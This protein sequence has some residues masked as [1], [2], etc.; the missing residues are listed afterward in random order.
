MRSNALQFVTN[1]LVTFGELSDGT[2]V[3]RRNGSNGA[4]LSAS[5]VKRLARGEVLVATIHS[6]LGAT[7]DRANGKGDHLKPS[8]KLRTFYAAIERD[9]RLDADGRRE[10]RD[11][12]SE[13][14]HDL[15]KG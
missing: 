4:K 3:S 7:I 14:Y 2:L 9:P 13:R 8:A 1:T 15:L 6:G 5:M 11:L 10:A 12:F